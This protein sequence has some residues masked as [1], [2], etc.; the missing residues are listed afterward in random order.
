M[1][2]CLQVSAVA[3]ALNRQL[4]TG[5][6]FLKKEETEFFKLIKEYFFEILL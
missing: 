5:Q 6:R 1:R 2:V 3:V 4:Y